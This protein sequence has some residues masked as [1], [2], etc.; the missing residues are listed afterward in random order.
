M[1]SF[2]LGTQDRSVCTNFLDLLT[3]RLKTVVCRARDSARREMVAGSAGWFFGSHQAHSCSHCEL[4]L[5]PAGL[6][7]LPQASLHPM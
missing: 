5:E 4:R 3:S 1:A 6:E 7:C 2:D